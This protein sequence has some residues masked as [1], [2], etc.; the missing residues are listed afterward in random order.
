MMRRRILSSML[1]V[2]SAGGAGS[3]LAAP[4]YTPDI[5]GILQGCNSSACHGSTN[6]PMG[7]LSDAQTNIDAIITT[8]TSD[9]SAPKFMPRG[10]SAMDAG[11]IQKLRD[12]K[13]A[14]FPATATTGAGSTGT[15]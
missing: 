14:N 10:G 8:V 9:P 5:Q 4:G 1:V 6:P 3:A 7:S 15:A 12:W 13:T 2:A 11:S